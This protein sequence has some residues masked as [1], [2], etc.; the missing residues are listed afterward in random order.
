MR[1]IVGGLAPPLSGLGWAVRVGILGVRVGPYLGLK[2]Y[3]DRIGTGEWRPMV[4][5]FFRALWAGGEAHSRLAEID[6]ER[7][8]VLT[9]Q[10]EEANGKVNGVELN[11]I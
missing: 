8:G 4:M 9:G 1:R 11:E 5:I 7:Y 2:G 10:G 3:G 6:E